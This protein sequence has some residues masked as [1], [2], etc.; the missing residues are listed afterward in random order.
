MWRKER[1]KDSLEYRELEK[2]VKNLIRNA[3]PSYEKKLARQSKDNSRPFYAYLKRKT[4]SRA[5]VGPIKDAQGNSVTDPKQMAEII[6]EYF[7]SVFNCEPAGPPPPPDESPHLQTVLTYFNITESKIK[8]K[9]RKL[10]PA[11]APGPDSIGAGLIQELQEELTPAL[12]IVFRKLLDEKHT[13][14]DWRTAH[15]TPIYKKG[16]KHEPGNYRPVSLTSVMCKLFEALVKDA[17]I[18]DLDQ[19]H[20]VTD[21][22]HGFVPSRSCAT[23]LI[24]FYDQVTLALDD[25]VPVDIVFLD[26]A[27][28]FDKVPHKALMSKLRAYGVWGKVGDWIEAWLSNRKMRVCINGKKSSWR[29][30]LSGVPQGSVLGPILFVLYIND[31]G[32]SISKAFYNMFTDDTKIGKAMKSDRDRQEMQEAINGADNWSK[33]WGMPFNVN[34]CKVMHMGKNNPKNVYTMAGHQLETTEVEKDVGVQK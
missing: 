6:N 9:I 16:P 19:N 4:K 12:R 2:K 11:A 29:N 32:H 27:K 8:E 28:A 26:F 5:S 22:Q 1:D 34:K 31:I 10:R 20:L 13:P 18:S 23:N 3:K 7:S 21:N 14:E 15:V 30:I 17:I 33:K 24:K 25:N